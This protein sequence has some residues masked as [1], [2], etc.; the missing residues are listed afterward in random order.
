MD[1]FSDKM[2][3][4]LE[5]LNYSVNESKA[6]LTL[7]RTGASLAGN[8]AKSASLDRSSTYNA[9]KSLVQRGVVST[10]H[11]N[12]RTIYVPENPKKI[13]D[14]YKEKEE[15]AKRIIP[16]LEKQFTYT[17]KV[18]SVKLFTG[19]KGVKT[20]FQDMIDSSDSK[21]THFVLGS[22]GYFSDLMPY[23]SPHFRKMKAKK[24]IR[25]KILMRTSREKRSKSKYTEYRSVPSDV[26]SPATINVYEDKVAI[27]IWGDTPESILIENKNVSKTL[28]NYFTFMWKH[29]KV[30]GVHKN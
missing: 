12:K 23:Y 29:A 20:V 25:S 2:F 17:K 4:D 18:S 26:E 21:T 8:I 11:E 10:I 27:F 1:V 24:R 16:S 15:I 28:M 7:L 5:K 19:F 6:Y 30:K 14:Y 13:V 3:R 9:L 22:E